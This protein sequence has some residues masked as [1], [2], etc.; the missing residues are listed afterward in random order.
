MRFPDGVA[1]A[2][3]LYG[4]DC[5]EWHVADATDARRLRAQRRY[6]GI[7]G[8]GGSPDTS[9][10]AKPLGPDAAALVAKLLAKP[11]TVYT[12]FADAR[13]DGKF[14][15]YYG[16]VETQT[17]KV[18]AEALVEAGLARAYGV[19]RNRTD[20]QSSDAYRDRLADLELRA[21]K[22]GVGAWAKTYWNSLPDERREE[23]E[24]EDELAAAT[25][26]KTIIEK[27]SVNPNSAPRD[28]LMQLPGICEKIAEPSP[29]AP[30]AP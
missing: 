18:L 1:R 30:P 16:F 12:A 26:G 15:R 2:I 8:F 3:R 14:K 17:R 19:Y 20:G 13:G 29:S 4:A 5:I 23:R 11:F 27:K 24:E 6:F 10:A 9:A 25:D 22:L 21:A 28:L 7:T